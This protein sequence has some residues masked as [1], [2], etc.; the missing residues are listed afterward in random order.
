MYDYNWRSTNN[1]FNQSYICKPNRSSPFF[2][3]F[4]R[5]NIQRCNTFFPFRPLFRVIQILEGNFMFCSKRQHLLVFY[6]RFLFWFL[7]LSIVITNQ[8]R[9]KIVN[10]GFVPI[11]DKKNQRLFLTLKIK[12]KTFF[13]LCI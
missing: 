9:E 11:S 5:H 3:E 13:Q 8:I 12:L 6:V 4:D 7:K 1:L 10:T 2:Q